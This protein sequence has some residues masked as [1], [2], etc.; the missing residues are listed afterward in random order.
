[1]VKFSDRLEAK[2]KQSFLL[3]FLATS[4]VVIHQLMTLKL[5]GLGGYF[6]SLGI[7]EAVPSNFTR[8]GIC[9]ILAGIVTSAWIPYFTTYRNYKHLEEID[10]DF[11]MFM[12][13]YAK[14]RYLQAPPM[15]EAIQSTPA[16]TISKT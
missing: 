5:E 9:M 11:L 7:K 10:T 8:G 1:M 3:E 2:A 12:E 15:S 16:P 14:E 4:L 6:F 13:Q